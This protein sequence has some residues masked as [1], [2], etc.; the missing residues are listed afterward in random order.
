VNVAQRAR[1]EECAVRLEK[2]SAA[3]IRGG[4]TQH[5]VALPVLSGQQARAVAEHV[6]AA[7]KASR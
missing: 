2:P 5:S 4:E 3:T 1:R 6:G 7:Q